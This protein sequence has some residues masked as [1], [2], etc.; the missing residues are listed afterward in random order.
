MIRVRGCN[1]N[2]PDLWIDATAVTAVATREIGGGQ[3]EVS[4]W[5]REMGVAVRRYPETAAL[6]LVSAIQAAKGGTAWPNS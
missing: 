3:I 5:V 6:E 1:A 2:D 4:I